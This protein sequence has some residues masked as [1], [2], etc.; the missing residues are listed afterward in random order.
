[1]ATIL[2]PMSENRGFELIRLA[3][4]NGT[5]KFQITQQTG[6]LEL[7]PSQAV[8]LAKALNWF[9]ELSKYGTGEKGQGQ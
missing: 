8:Y 5:T 9:V 1:M 2:V 3:G 6:F 7:T 4:P